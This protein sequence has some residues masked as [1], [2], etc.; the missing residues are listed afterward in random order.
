MELMYLKQ[1][2]ILVKLNITKSVVHENRFVNQVAFHK[3][4]TRKDATVK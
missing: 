4:V 3:H 2:T 1:S